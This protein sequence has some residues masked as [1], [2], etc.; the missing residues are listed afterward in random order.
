MNEE[1][2]RFTGLQKLSSSGTE[3]LDVTVDCTDCAKPR[4]I[5]SKVKLTPREVR[6]LKLLLNS[7]DY[8]CRAVITTDGHILQ[9]IFYKSYSTRESLCETA[10]QLPVTHRIWIL[11][12]WYR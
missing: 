2:T 10:T 7:H 9:V 5:Y 4:C 6:T 11:F 3:C 12:F 1:A 8:S